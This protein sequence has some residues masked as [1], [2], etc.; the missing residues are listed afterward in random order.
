MSHPDTGGDI[1]NNTNGEE[2]SQAKRLHDTPE[3]SGGEEGHARACKRALRHRKRKEARARRS[4][5]AAIRSAAPVTPAHL[6]TA[7]ISIDQDINADK[8]RE[9]GRA[10]Y[11]KLPEPPLSGI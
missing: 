7:N 9:V 8:M 11:V 3:E 10:A 2:G 4:K 1:T 5:N 6:V